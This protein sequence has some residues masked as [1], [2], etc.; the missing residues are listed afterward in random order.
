MSGKCIDDDGDILYL[1]D[2]MMYLQIGKNTALELF[3][4][5]EFPALNIDNRKKRVLKSDL[6]QYL[7][8]IAKW[9]PKQ[10]EM[11]RAARRFAARFSLRFG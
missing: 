6:I 7:E 1:R 5:P 9:H 4:T 10:P 11:G 2:V 8:R 3:K